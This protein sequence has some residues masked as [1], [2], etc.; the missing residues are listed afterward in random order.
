MKKE[1]DIKKHYASGYE[2]DRLNRGPGLLERAR[3]Q[4]LISRFLEPPP[5]VVFDVGGGTGVYSLWLAGLGYELHLLDIVPLH[6]ELAK[7]ASTSAESRLAE[8][9]AGDARWLPWKDGTADVVILFGPLYHLTDADAR[10]KALREAS[11]VLK[12]GGTLLASGISR[13]AS[14]L[15]GI[16]S[17]YLTDPEFAAIVENDLQD[18]H[19]RNPSGKPEYFMD[20]FFHHPGELGAEIASAGFK[21]VG[22]YGVEGPGWLAPD[23]EAWWR[24][25][26]RQERLLMLARELER[27]PSL[28]GL[29]AHLIVVGRKP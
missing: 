9:V 23:I 16:R 18:G 8:G 24:H 28:L 25:P 7:K 1:A 2:E 10:G 13:F 5:A 14:T 29:S 3:S 17:G 12:H 26:E 4:E 15:D 21:E 19:H 11:R 27:E 20:S 22:V 6:V